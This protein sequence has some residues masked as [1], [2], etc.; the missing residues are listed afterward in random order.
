MKPLFND[1]KREAQPAAAPSLSVLTTG[2]MSAH[3]GATPPG[4]A[5]PKLLTDDEIDRLGAEQGVRMAAFSK[6]MLS[7]VRAADAGQFGDKLNELIATAKGLDPN[8]MQRGGVLARVS[9]FL[10]STRERLLAQYETVSKRLDTLLRELETHAHQQKSGIADLEQMYVDNYAMHQELEA[11]RQHG[12]QALAAFRAVLAGEPEAGD[13]FAAQRLLDVR[14]RISAL[15]Q[16][17]DDL[18]RAMLMSKQLAP[19]IRMEQDHKRT[20]TSKFGTIKTVLIP[21]WTNAFSLYLEQLS[22]RRAAELANATYDAADAA[23][24]AQADLSRANAQ[25]IAKL[26]QRPVIATSTFEYAQEQ[27]FGAFD[28]ITRIVDEGR[29]QREQEAPRLRQLEQDLVTRFTRKPA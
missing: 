19:Q 12:E 26:G 27:L 25:E 18:N 10:K 9:G 7:S 17:I 1:E 14:R 28:D 5:L 20:L 16:K 13:A 23:I 29:R 22:T 4:A 6:Q 21:A 11:A 3:A 15:E 24:R 2:A 8:A